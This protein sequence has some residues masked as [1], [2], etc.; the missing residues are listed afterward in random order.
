M[1]RRGPEGRPRKKIQGEWVVRAGRAELS[2]AGRGAGWAEAAA[3][4]CAGFVV[5]LEVGGQG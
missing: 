5:Q 1:R 2:C 3:L 4:F